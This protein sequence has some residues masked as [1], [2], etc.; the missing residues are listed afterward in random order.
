MQPVVPTGDHNPSS[1]TETEI[2]AGLRATGGTRRWSFRYEL[3]DDSNMKIDDLNNVESG[4][5]EQ[6]WLADIKRTATFT[7]T[8]V[9]Y[10]DYLSDR[11]RPYVR[12]HLAPYGADDWVEWPQGVFVLSTPTRSTSDVGHVNRSVDGYD[13]LQFLADDKVANRYVVTAGTV[14]TTAV[15]TLLP[16]A[17][18]VHVSAL[19]APTDIEWDPG[20][21]KLAIVNDLLST[22]NYESLSVDE[23]GVFEVRPYRTPTERGPEYTYADDRDGLMLPAIDQTLDLFAIPNNWV[24]VVSQP[25]RDPLVATYTNNDPASLTSTVRRGGRTITD[26]A[27]VNDAADQATLDGIVARAAFEGSQ[28]YEAIEFSTGMLPIHS[29]NDVYRI[30]FGPLGVDDVYAE[31]K[32]SMDLKAGAPMTHRARRLV[33]LT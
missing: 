3:L 8:E 30:T 13:L 26:F 32:W 1:R 11:I 21:S 15:N 31:H 12:L 19:T 29:G 23:N 6:N 27:S 14:Y 5:V 9:D 16:S 10:I 4:K 7:L 18:N 17:G 2:L 24:R 25:D 33:S 22:V 28:V 20:T